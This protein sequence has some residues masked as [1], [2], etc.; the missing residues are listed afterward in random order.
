MSAFYRKHFGYS[1]QADPDDRI[2]ELVPPQGGAILML[3]PLAKSQKAG[4]VLVK[5]VFEVRDVDAFRDRA[6]REGL[7]FG[8][9]HKGDGYV[10]ANAKDPSGNSI[11][12][13]SR[14][15]R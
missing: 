15:F 5:L 10:F 6:D 13:S 1:I 7:K 11:S 12:I 2:I 4:Q 8:P 9:S 14:G 3:H